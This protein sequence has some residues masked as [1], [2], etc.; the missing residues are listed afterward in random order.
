[1]NKSDKR[2][3]T[4]AL[5]VLLSGS[6]FAFID[7]EHLTNLWKPTNEAPATADPARKA[8]EVGKA[9]DGITAISTDRSK[10]IELAA[11]HGGPKLDLARID[12]N[13]ASVL[14]GTGKP[15]TRVLVEADGKKVGVAA[16][17]ANGEWVLVTDHKFASKDPKIKVS[18][19]AGEATIASAGQLA[20]PDPQNRAAN[21]A[22]RQL[23]TLKRMIK[24]ARE[25]AEAQQRA[26]KAEEREIEARSAERQAS[27][28]AGPNG[29]A[30]QPDKA[31]TD[32]S[33]Q[34]MAAASM[35]ST[36][37]EKPVAVPV[38]IG[39]VYKEAEFTSKGRR[40]ASLLL[41]Y[42]KLKNPATVTLTGHADEVGS[43]E[44]NMEL[45]RKRLET[46]RDYLRKGGFS[47]EPKLI[48]KG[49]SEPYRNVDRTQ[50]TVETL[51]E[52]DRRV[53][54]QLH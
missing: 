15:G 12:A 11:A 14:A 34:K 48:P 36:N 37:S 49:E 6:A 46:V 35:A 18:T 8:P 10:R 21:E 26:I 39:F 22:D 17:D 4:I 9:A 31:G 53:E 32:V 19:A 28:A 20:T 3:L 7:R 30:R 33:R 2:K 52:L 51:H 54:L 23:S 45:S 16:A 24:T 13:G 5:A 1:M 29:A 47:G 42:L 43:Q 50:L 44:F 40:A 27:P 41:E 38:P 25:Q